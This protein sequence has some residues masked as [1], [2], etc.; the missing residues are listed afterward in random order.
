MPSCRGEMTVATAGQRNGKRALRTSQNSP[1]V[2]RNA[3]NGERTPSSN[4]DD[5]DFAAT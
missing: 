5:D 1:S 2:R 3:T 4:D